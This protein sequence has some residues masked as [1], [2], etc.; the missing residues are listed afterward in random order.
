MMLC[1]AEGSILLG[2]PKV[3]ACFFWDWQLEATL[4]SSPK[5]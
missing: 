3:N 2:Y 5:I 4:F 1:G